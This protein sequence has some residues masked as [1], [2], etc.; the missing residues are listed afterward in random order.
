MP[1]FDDPSRLRLTITHPSAYHGARRRRCAAGARPRLTLVY[2]RRASRLPFGVHPALPSTLA[3]AAVSMAA[4]AYAAFL[5]VANGVGAI[6]TDVGA[7]LQAV[8]GRRP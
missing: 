1:R 4:L 2:S 5:D 3:F 7:R 8:S 6:A